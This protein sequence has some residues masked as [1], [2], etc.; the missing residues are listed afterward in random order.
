[1]GGKGGRP[2]KMKN[3]FIVH[4]TMEMDCKNY[5]EMQAARMT[6]QEGK[7]FCINELIRMAIDNYFPEH[8]QMNMELKNG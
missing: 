6:L 3:P 1:M 7:K 4:L 8:K 5:L 2:R